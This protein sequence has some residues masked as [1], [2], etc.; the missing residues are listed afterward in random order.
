MKPIIVA[1]DFGLC[2]KHDEVITKLVKKKK[3]N[4]VS[5]LVHGELTKERVYKIKN[6][7]DYVSIGLHLNL[8]MTL[9]KI[10]PLGSIKTLI[11]KSFLKVIN[12]QELEK[13]V[14]SQISQ[15]EEIFG[16]PPDFI[17]G[18][19]HVHTLPL[20]TEILI[21]RVLKEQFSK[22]FWIRSPTTN[23]LSDLIREVSNAGVKVVIIAA[24]AKRA[25]LKLINHKIKT[26]NNF[27]GFLNLKSPS[28]NFEQMYLKLLTLNKSDMVLMVHP[29]DAE[30]PI[31]NKDH[32]NELRALEAKLLNS[33]EIHLI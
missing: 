26:N 7:R 15:F 13:T 21:E 3:V 14:N 1:D 33:S 28:K 19:E 23:T 29:G 6:M 10:K 5:V 2:E 18:H 9:P 22:E 32:S 17:D 12:L 27:A 4:A 8:T 31:F 25:K 20:V 30:S 24:L 16:S 11:F